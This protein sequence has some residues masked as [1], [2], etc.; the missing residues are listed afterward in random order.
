MN[1]PD[2]I[3][4]HL[5]TTSPGWFASKMFGAQCIKS[6]QTGKAA[7]MLY[8]NDMVFKLSAEDLTQTLNI[9]A[10]HM[11]EPMPGRPM[12]GWVRV[13]A[14]LSD[15][16]LDLARLAMNY[17]SGIE[18]RKV[19]PAKKSSA[20]KKKTTAPKKQNEGQ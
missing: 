10:C 9:S 4:N 13:P 8:K 20:G 5:A 7:I 14:S 15:K 3:F 18:T 17:V 11:F 6:E 16:W 2:D 1:K 12:N 19:T